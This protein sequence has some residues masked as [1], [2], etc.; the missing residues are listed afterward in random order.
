MGTESA[1]HSVPTL[2]EML[3]H[4]SAIPAFYL[5]VVYILPAFGELTGELG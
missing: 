1:V 5:V 3:A 2:L 4:S